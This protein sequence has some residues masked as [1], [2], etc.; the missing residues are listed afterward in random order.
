LFGGHVLE[1]S[2]HETGPGV[3]GSQSAQIG[4][5]FPCEREFRQAEVENFDEAIFRNHEVARFQV[6]VSDACFVRLCEALR[7]LRGD[8]DC[9]AQGQGSGE[10]QFAESVSLHQ[11]HRD[12][13][14][15]AVLPEFVDRDDIGMVEGRRGTRFSLEA[16]QPI[17]VSGECRGKNFNGEIAAEASIP[18][19]VDF[20]HAA[21]A[22]QRFDLVGAQ[23]GA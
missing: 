14:G 1:R 5:I 17:R 8:F 7:N 2:Q 10:K 15:G 21:S 6:A 20:A 9:F 11:F 18:C 16:L 19:A 4:K 13:V 12:V 22:Q 3:G 23:V